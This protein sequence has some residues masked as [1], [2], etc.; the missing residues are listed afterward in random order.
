MSAA[1]LQ[2]WPPDARSRLANE[3]YDLCGLGLEAAVDLPGPCEDPV[4]ETA[5]RLQAALDQQAD[6][7]QTDRLR[8]LLTALASDRARSLDS[9]TAN[10]AEILFLDRQSR[11]EYRDNPHAHAP[12][13][14]EK[15]LLEYACMSRQ[16]DALQARLTK[17]FCARRCP[18]PPV[19][20]CHILGYDLGL[21]PERMLS[22]QRL[23]ARWRGWRALAH[24]SKCRYHTERG[25]VLVLF[26]SP[27][28]IGHLCDVLLDWLGETH[29]PRLL[30]PFLADLAA[31]RNCDLD[32][33]R[34]FAAG[35][36]AVASGRRLIEHAQGGANAAS[37]D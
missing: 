27:A 2:P 16:L 13:R 17:D 25:C 20:C 37:L 6:P 18:K 3:I 22:L 4:A 15:L 9:V 1:Q 33:E 10:L 32:R 36:A 28:C 5:G 19:G 35:Q 8:A 11:S 14:I 34:I 31:F 30:D 7:R 23:E 21:V 29:P 12:Y 26:K 24:E